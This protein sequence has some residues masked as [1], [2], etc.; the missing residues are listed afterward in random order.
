MDAIRFESPNR[1]LTD[2]LPR[3][4]FLR[5]LAAGLGLTAGLPRGTIEARQKRNGGNKALCLRNGS[6]CKQKGKTCKAAN[7]LQAPFTV[8]ARWSTATSDHD[9]YVFMPNVPGAAFP[10]PFFSYTCK[11]ND[12]GAGL[13]EPFAFVSGDATGPGN[14]VTT[15]AFL[16]EGTYEYWI[17]LAEFVPAGDLTVT[18]R[19][20]NGNVVRSWSSPAN[21]S[22]ERGWHVFDIQG[23]RKSVTSVNRLIDATL[24][25]GAHAI[26]TRVCPK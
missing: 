16:L 19:N 2:L 15:V 7:C 21:P 17:E 12:A 13:L 14:E 18:L 11:S 25:F 5:R 24:P 4:N 6:H 1:V 26:A 10:F 3:R 22:S 20:A 9:T 8:E 23:Q